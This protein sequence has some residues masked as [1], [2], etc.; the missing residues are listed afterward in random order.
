MIQQLIVYVADLAAQRALTDSAHRLAA[1][2]RV[3]AIALGVLAAAAIAT[4]GY[5]VVQQGHASQQ[6]DAALL[7]QSRFLSDAAGTVAEQG[8]VRLARLLALAALPKDLDHPDRPYVPD[9]VAALAQVWGQDQLEAIRLPATA[10]AAQARTPAAGPVSDRFHKR[11]DLLRSLI[12]RLSTVSFAS[13]A[14]GASM[15]VAGDGRVIVYDLDSKVL[16]DAP[17]GGARSGVAL[18]ATGAHMAQAEGSGVRLWDLAAKSSRLLTTSFVGADTPSLLEFSAD[19]TRLM[20]GGKAGNVAIFSLPDGRRIGGEVVDRAVWNL[21]VSPNSARGVAVGADGRAALFDLAGGKLISRLGDPGVAKPTNAE[22]LRQGVTFLAQFSADSRLVATTVNATTARIWDAAT[23][24]AIGGPLIHD[25][26]ISRMEFNPAGD[27]LEVTLNDG[28][29]WVWRTLSPSTARPLA[30]GV[31]SVALG[32]DGKRLLVTDAA[33]MR[34][35]DRDGR[36]LRTVVSAPGVTDCDWSPSGEAVAGIVDHNRVILAP[37]GG[38][39][40][41]TVYQARPG[42]TVGAV[43]FTSKGGRL[44]VLM[45]GGPSVILDAATGGLIARFGDGSRGI[46][47][48]V[49]GTDNLLFYVKGGDIIEFGPDGA[50][51]AR[52]KGSGAGPDVMGLSG[53]ADTAMAVGMGASVDLWSLTDGRLLGHADDGASFAATRTAA[54]AHPGGW[55]ARADVNKSISVWPW[56]AEGAGAFRSGPVR[57][58]LGH[59]ATISRLKVTANGRLLSLDQN[60][61]AILWDALAGRRLA[62]YDN[63]ANA[64]LSADGQAVALISPAGDVRLADL[65]PAGAALV[66]QA[67]AKGGALSAAERARYFLPPTG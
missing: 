33:G 4:G 40:A 59:D 57:R 49:T 14:D 30:S 8:D 1:R 41:R 31:Q 50:A 63:A 47:S 65:P 29:V 54:V 19:G 51:I 52:L 46:L 53:D 66:A 37:A 43:L 58:L 7:S 20:A 25:G 24:E 5:A 15:V 17:L 56:P 6:R 45:G 60:G 67:R 18:D 10:A 34:I 62:H 38:G 22:T 27:R 13:S 23:G 55:L 3:A 32:A 2:T 35:L 16:L 36:T 48:V 26:A 9:A 28:R 44:V 42:E 21:K 12:A 11:A 64:R 61:V 39:A